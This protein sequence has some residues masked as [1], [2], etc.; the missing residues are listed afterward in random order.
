MSTSQ[1]VQ[2]GRSSQLS[3]LSSS[4]CASSDLEQA[5]NA[6]SSSSS[7]SKEAVN[8]ISCSSSATEE[9]FNAALLSSSC[10]SCSTN[11]S[12]KAAMGFA[13]MSDSTI[14]SAQD[15]TVCI[16]GG[17]SKTWVQ[18]I[19]RYNECIMMECNG[20]TGDSVVFGSSNITTIQET[21]LWALLN[22]MVSC[23]F[24]DGQPLL[25]LVPRCQ[26]VAGMAGVS[27][28]MDKV[29]S[30][31]ENIGFSKLVLMTDGD[32]ALQVLKDKGVILISGTGS[33]CRGK[34]GDQEARAG[35][36]GPIYGD[37]GSGYWLGKEALALGIE[38]EYGE[39]ITTS[40]LPT[41][42]AHFNVES[43][44]PFIPKTSSGQF[45]IAEIAGASPLVF[46]L[47]ES[48]NQK[49]DNLVQTAKRDLIELVSRVVTQLNLSD[50]EIHLWGGTFKNR[51]MVEA[52]EYSQVVCERNMTVV[53]N[54]GNNVAT[55]YAKSM[56]QRT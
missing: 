54:Y 19:D 7:P 35:G 32:M 2:Y 45:S 4:S 25:N 27:L 28:H 14:E 50:C 40:L 9:A 10:G 41:L 42:K 13:G 34:K 22:S 43:L 15:L 1:P 17:G 33:I 47:A 30:I 55:V 36:Y 49:A 53:V 8:A 11:E 20:T 51:T 39:V 23:I 24:I 48:G 18:V 26:V 38:E 29:I 56:L 5:V 31:F 3:D 21:G 52:I 37:K 46:S 44:K 12:L 6:A 16:D